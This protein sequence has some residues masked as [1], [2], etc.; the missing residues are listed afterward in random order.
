MKKLVIEV[1][2]KVAKELLNE[3]KEIFIG[4]DWKDLNLISEIY[5][6]EVNLPRMIE[7]R[8]LRKGDVIVNNDEEAEVLQVMHNLR[9]GKSAA[10]L[11]GYNFPIEDAATTL[12]ELRYRK[13]ES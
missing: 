12:V 3:P 7:M 8:G 1:S 5:P 2:D 13:G 11:A 4:A 10:M 9:G 6:L